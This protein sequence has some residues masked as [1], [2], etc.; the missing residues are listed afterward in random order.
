MSYILDALK[1][2]D[3]ERGIAKVPT[4]GTIH[5]AA[6]KSGNVRWAA[7]A[8]ILILTAAVAGLYMYSGSGSNGNDPASTNVVSQN[9]VPDQSEEAGPDSSARPDEA[10]LI[11]TRAVSDTV[12]RTP[13][14]EA[15]QEAPESSIARSRRGETPSSPSTGYLPSAPAAES[16]YSGAIDEEFTKS[17]EE[18]PAVNRKTV[19]MAAEIT[20]RPAPLNEAVQE[21]EV[22][23]HLYSDVAESRKIFING[24]K[25]AEGDYV[26][27]TYLIE[28]ITPEG[29][30]LSYEGARAVIKA[31]D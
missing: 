1:K 29:A 27:G 9:P 23:I 18:N 6:P 7:I 4:L 14:V 5:A 24:K 12:P 17:V 26:D 10:G 30:V 28:S 20:P 3:R 25:Y 15:P 2:A 8:F 11:Q 16:S 22:T 21:M 19:P 31:A 13:P